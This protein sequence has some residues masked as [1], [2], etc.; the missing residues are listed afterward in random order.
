MSEA[1]GFALIAVLC[2]AGW[3]TTNVMMTRASVQAANA[4]K[5][6]F[7]VDATVDDR[8]ASQ[9]QRIEQRRNRGA[10]PASRPAPQEPANPMAAIFAV[11]GSP[12]EEQPDSDDERLEVVS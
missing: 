1:L 3:A 11:P 4:L 9:I 5:I 7:Q 8:I 2:L 6:L 12:I 10:A